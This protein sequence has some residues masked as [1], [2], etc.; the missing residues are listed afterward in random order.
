M[1][2]SL[3]EP[4]HRILVVDDNQSIHND[5]RKILLGDVRVQERL[6]DDEAFL[7]GRDA[8]PVTKSPLPLLTVNSVGVAGT[9]IAFEKVI[10]TIV[11]AV[12]V[13]ALETVGGGED[14]VKLFPYKE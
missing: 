8:A 2:T 6:Q 12:F 14:S 7:F 5:L 9:F 4:N 11:P 1:T 10:E 13:A 3:L